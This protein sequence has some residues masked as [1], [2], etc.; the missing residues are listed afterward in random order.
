M[1]ERPDYVLNFVKPPKTEIKKIGANNW[2]LYEV[3]YVYSPEAKRTRK[4]SGRCLGKIT[5]EG[6]VPS[7]RR[8]VKAEVPAAPV[9]AC[10]SASV[11]TP[12]EKAPTAASPLLEDTLEVGA[13]IWYSERTVA[14]RERLRR[15]FPDHWAYLYVIALLK[16]CKQAD[17]KRLQLRFEYSLLRLLFPIL[18][19]PAGGVAAFLRDFGKYRAEIT[20]FMREDVS[21]SGDYLL[22][23]GRC[24]MPLGRGVD[25]EACERRGAEPNFAA[26]FALENGTVRPVYYKLCA[27][28]TPDATAFDDVMAECG[29]EASRC[30]VVGDDGFRLGN[31]AELSPDAA[32]RIGDACR[33]IARFYEEFGL[34]T[35]DE[36][37]YRRG[38]SY[39]ESLLFLA[40]LSAQAGLAS[41][42]E[43][44]S[45]AAADDDALGD[46]HT[47]LNAIKAVK[48]NGTWHIPPIR[49]SVRELLDELKADISAEALDAALKAAAGQQATR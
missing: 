25:D 49:P 38:R 32:A 18:R 22:V 8:A 14:L 23:P 33:V 42:A 12:A 26:V 2:Y 4:V 1:T 29:L 34:L 48:I 13:E 17:V 10:A 15:Y 5:P 46:L 39:R 3:G 44:R 45:E 19:F 6:L 41:L 47:A 30:V 27:E 9:S 20:A 16:L 28:H 43:I 7:K 36:A 11:P 21:A 31:G 40:H 24:L 35:A 37:F